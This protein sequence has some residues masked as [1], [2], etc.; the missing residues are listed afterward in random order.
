MEI[1]AAGAPVA[2]PGDDDARLS[3][4][5]EG[6]GRAGRHRQIVC[7]VTDKADDPAFEITHVHVAVFAFRRPCPLSQVLR[8]HFAR[9]DASNQE[10]SHVAVERGDDIVT[11]ECGGIP[12]CDG[13]HAVAGVAAADDPPLTI[14]RGDAILQSSGKPEVVI[15]VEQVGS[16]DLAGHVCQ[17]HESLLAE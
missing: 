8:E 6:Q 13:L 1:S 11:L 17:V 14:E 7:Q 9:R 2:G 5:L 10:G 3:S 12:D 4:H 15:H 16:F